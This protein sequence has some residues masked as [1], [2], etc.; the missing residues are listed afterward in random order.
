MTKSTTDNRSASPH[1]VTGHRAF[2][3]VTGGLGQ[4]EGGGRQ[5]RQDERKEKYELI[6]QGSGWEKGRN[7]KKGNA[8][9]ADFPLGLTATRVTFNWPG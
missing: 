8:S 6:N 7:E 5:E 1:W 4:K 2:P 3:V 9:F